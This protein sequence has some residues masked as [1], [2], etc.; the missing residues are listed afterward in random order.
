MAVDEGWL[1]KRGSR[2]GIEI[3]YFSG[4]GNSLAVARDLADRLDARLRPIPTTIASQTVTPDAAAIG[5]V[6]PVYHG[7][8]PLIVKR[9]VERLE[10]L[11][12]R[13]LFGVSTYG[14]TPGMAQRDLEGLI[15]ARGGR[16]AAGF[17]IHMPYN[18]LTPSP[19]LKGFLRS[20]TLRQIPIEEQQALFDAWQARVEPIAAQLREHK[21]APLQLGADPIH[22]LFEILHLQESL[23]KAVWLRVAG[24]DR[25]PVGSFIE[26]RQ[27]MDR[28]FHADETCTG[29][30]TCARICPVGNI[31][32][33]EGRPVWQQRCEQCFACLQ[34]CPQ[35]ALQF[36]ARTAGRPRYHHPQVRLADML[37][38]SSPGAAPIRP[39]APAA[40]GTRKPG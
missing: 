20:F 2:M 35:Q 36:G 40:P 9:F 32:M 15:R 6:F 24:V 31:R 37:R 1:V 18:Y 17:A 30:G 34:W 13:Y 14:D 33:E 22:R 5:I 7:S 23:G 25:P 10:G 11:E 12:D 8:L 39:G 26:S 29:C 38:V 27:W 4:T 19:V 21:T 16:L 3:A 28:A